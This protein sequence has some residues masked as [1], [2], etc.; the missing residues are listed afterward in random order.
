MDFKKELENDKEYYE[1]FLLGYQVDLIIGD[2]LVTYEIDDPVELISNLKI[3]KEDLMIL[4]K[5]RVIELVEEK[6]YDVKGNVKGVRLNRI[7]VGNPV[8]KEDKKFLEELNKA[9]ISKLDC[10]KNNCLWWSS[11]YFIA[12]LIIGLL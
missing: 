3:A 4:D 12:R 5:K 8:T 7:K 1:S 10:L 6:M 11:K 9:S 2:A